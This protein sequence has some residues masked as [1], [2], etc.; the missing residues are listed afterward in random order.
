MIPADPNLS[1][2]TVLKY[3]GEIHFPNGS[4]VYEAEEDG[5]S[6]YVST[7]GNNTRGKSV[8]RFPVTKEGLYN[9]FKF[10]Q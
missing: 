10:L 2:E 1:V 3:G 4:F 5:E 8:R 6:F 9:A 7:R